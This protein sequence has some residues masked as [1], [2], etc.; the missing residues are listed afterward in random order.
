MANTL[1]PL[2]LVLVVAS[3]CASAHKRQSDLATQA[4]A[5]EVVDARADEK[6]VYLRYSGV[7]EQ[8]LDIE[9]REVL[10]A[11]ASPVTD[12]DLVAPLEF[13]GASAWEVSS[14]TAEPVAVF[15]VFFYDDVCD[16]VFEAAAPANPGE[17]VSV[18]ADLHEFVVWRDD[19]GVAHL[20]PI[21]EVIADLRLVAKRTPADLRELALEDLA[22][23][24][25]AGTRRALVHTGQE[26]PGAAPFLYVDLDRGLL[27]LLKVKGVRGPRPLE[28]V[29]MTVDTGF[30][31]VLRSFFLEIPR[32]PFRMA[33]RTAA[34]AGNTAGDLVFANRAFDV[35]PVEAPPLHDGLGMDLEEFEAV[36]DRR[37]GT[38]RTSGRVIRCLIGGDEFFPVLREAVAQAKESVHLRTYLFDNDDFG[39]LIADALKRRSNEGIDVRILTDGLGTIIAGTVDSPRMPADFSKPP[40]ISWYLTSGSKVKYRSQSNPFLM[41]DHAK[42]T[43]IDGDRAFV[44]GMNIGREY[45]Y[46]YHDLMIEVTGPVVDVLEQEFRNIWELAGLFGDWQFA[47]YGLFG[48]KVPVR[49]AAEVDYPIRVLKT[50]PG[51][52]QIYKAQMEAIRRAKRYI[53]IENL[54]FSNKLFLQEVINARQRGVDVRVVMPLKGNWGIL[55]EAAMV[56]ANKMFDAGIRVYMYP[57][58][59]HTKA[60]V[61]DGW[62]CVG[63]ANF[64]K[65][66]FRVNEEINLGYT[67]P[68]A[69]QELVERLFETDFE[70]ATEMTERFDMNALNGLAEIIANQL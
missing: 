8:V 44:G 57:R 10:H 36:L 64:D 25:P 60:A 16:A 13:V 46:E 66:S 6:K 61:Y 49:E 47:L 26:G 19:A 52:S 48:E 63:S 42:T 56:T 40:K 65:L 18:R 7:V 28:P 24:L 59:T 1:V 37:T 39:V 20:S 12:V 17:A 69:V 3:G 34:F 33:V 2:L 31:L 4:V 32:S 55:T 38:K 5:V 14:A 11:T 9:H 54:Y 43:I 27:N 41:G 53:Y 67:D 29:G 68:E 22:Q 30:H 35:G 15:P 21:D 50:V 62:A 58:L 45:R 51:N 23:R 70:T